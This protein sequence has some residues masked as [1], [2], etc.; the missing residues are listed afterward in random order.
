M[1]NYIIF[2]FLCSSSIVFAQST[3][4][5]TLLH[6][7]QRKADLFYDQ[8]SWRN[9]L[10]LYLRITDKDPADLHARQRIAECYVKLND[11]ISAELWYSTLVKEVDAPPSVKYEYAEVLSKNSKYGEAIKWYELYAQAVPTDPLP[12]NKLEFIQHLDYYLRDSLLFKIISIGLNSTHSDFGPSYFKG[13]LVFVSSRDLDL[14]VKRHSLASQNDEEAL[15]N[16]FYSKKNNVTGDFDRVN[17]FSSGN[18]KSI[19]HDG[20]IAFYDH[21][22]K[23]AF[24]RN[25]RAPGWKSYKGKINLKIFLAD[26]EE[27]GTLKNIKPFPYSNDSSSM[28]HASFANGGNVMYFSSD[29]PSGYGGADIYFSVN[30]NGEW[31]D[32]VN[33]GPL[34]N[35]SGNEFYPFMANDSTLYFASNG[36]GGLGGLDIF[37]S[38]KRE[39]NFK[40]ATNLGYPL[41]TA[42]DDFSMVTDSTG[43]LGYFSSNR[44]GGVGLDDIYLFAADHYFVV[45][46]TRE[47]P[48]LSNIIPD[49]SIYV[50][51]EKGILIDS[52]RSN[53]EGYFH[54]DLQLDENFS[55]SAKKEGYDMLEDIGF[56]TKGLHFGV[57]SLA[58]PLWKRALFAKGKI[59]SNE[60]HEI[61]PEALV[62]LKN[63]TDNTIDSVVSH[64]GEYS[65]L[66]HPNKK[67]SIKVEKEGFIPD[68]FNLNTKDLYKGE[69][70][71][72]IVLEEIYV[73]KEVIQFDYNKHDIKPESFVHL[74]RIARTLKKF[75]K[76]TLNIGAYA[77][78]RGTVEYN[79]ALSDRRA[80]ATVEYFLRKGIARERIVARGF[81]EELILNRCSD[82]VE[83]TEEEHSKNR[84][85]ELKVQLP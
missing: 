46:R 60:T 28:A 70:L 1:K 41:N 15:L 51:D 62:T 25:D 30:K 78:A 29:I 22:K 45:G 84:R 11:P 10:E 12:K 7:N 67:Y 65:F 5:F 53:K 3:N 79:Q 13:G 20:P 23:A 21:Y 34:V 4:I 26:V 6:N 36:H 47:F 72:D 71:N 57:D 39:G 24:T 61:I 52:A 8:M 38:N 33:A 50:R 18:L 76:Q 59:Y 9:A 81:G 40:K 85:A 44:T 27:S 69:L 54:L 49:V 83:C 68:G 17:L 66:V 63:V 48:N 56:S 2:F 64:N 19:Y 43:R 74:N 32:P 35:T 82:G 73:E 75:P 37:V 55:I 16:L 58:F 31:S 14:F 80:N 42:Y 77:D